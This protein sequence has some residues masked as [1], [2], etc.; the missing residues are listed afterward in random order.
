[1]MTLAPDH[2]YPAKLGEPPWNPLHARS[3]AEADK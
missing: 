3:A 1:V 2:Q